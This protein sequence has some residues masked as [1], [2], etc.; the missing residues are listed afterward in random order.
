MRSIISSKEA[1]NNEN[2]VYYFKKVIKSDTVKES[3]INIFAESR[4]KL[5]VNGKLL[6]VGP[7]KRSTEINYYDTIDITDALISGDNC[8]ELSVMQLAERQHSDETFFLM[9]L[10]RN[11]FLG[12]CLWGN[13]GETPLVSDESWLVA[14]EKNME[15]F[16]ENEQPY[17][18]VASISEKV[19]KDYRKKLEYTN[20]IV[21]KEVYNFDEEKGTCSE[22]DITLKQ[23]PIPMMYFDNK[24]F[25]NIFHNVYDAGKVTCG[26]PQIKCHG[27]GEIKITYAEGMAFVEENGDIKRRKRDDENGKIIG[28]YDIIEVCGDT[29]FEPFWMRTFRYIKLEISGGVT[30]DDFHYIETGYP[31]I[32]SNEYDFG[33]D[34]DNKL[35]DISVNTLMRCMHETY[36]DCPYY[37]QLQY[38]MD[39]HLQMLFTY[40]LTQDKALPEKA[41][42][43]FASSY[44][45]G[46]LTQSRF[47]SVKAQ[48]I[49][50]FSLFFIMMLYEHTKRFSDKV[51]IRKYIHIADGVI[52]WFVRRLDGYLVSRSNLW[53][54]VDWSDE[55]DFGQPTSKGPMTVYSM[56]L[57]YC[58]EKTAFMHKF[59]GDTISDYDILSEKIK[60]DIKE[61]C[62]DVE[63]GMY[64][65]SPD[66]SHF[67]QHPQIW[68]VLTNM[69]TGENS[70]EILIKS[71]NLP[72]S[73][74]SAY[75]FF[76]FRAYE[77]AGIYDMANFHIDKLR[78]LID[79]GCTTT[80]E[81]IREDVR[82]ECHAWSAV[83]IYEFT[84]KVLGVTYSNGTIHIKPYITGRTY[85]KGEV[86]TPC[87]MLWIEWKIV[88]N[89]FE[90]ILNLPEGQTAELTM[91][92][93][94][95]IKA[96]SG[97]YSTFI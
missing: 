47:P 23:R 32:V 42:D 77:K 55:Y 97:H 27:I 7:C 75:M 40:Q 17:Y 59:I 31:L 53:D 60:N 94:T 51:F 84:A 64:A 10:F 24:K 33:N 20:A 19:G 44:R 85:S 68:S 82:S 37:E 73:I 29:T 66:K 36:M 3:K 76:L 95:I 11:G 57:A 43:D 79:L 56:M 89:N 87:G 12:L 22:F 28:Q 81:W 83:A 21:L 30:I 86:A 13:V 54:F 1:T 41:I 72:C 74:T 61:R 91:P 78:T 18:N 8:L 52:D 69:E 48:Y 58:L 80:P 90:I 62:Y 45:V 15:F 88:D 5:Y 96:A 26:Y 67:S 71:M 93:N 65:D 16:F 50:G 49:P 34:T 35:F 63:K 70:K 14:K 9:S 2:C 38:T 4:Y 25:V 39:T 6:A 92:D 46:N